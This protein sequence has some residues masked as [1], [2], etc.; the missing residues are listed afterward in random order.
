MKRFFAVLLTL[1]LLLPLP[2]LA[3]DQADLMKKIDELS[4]ELDKLKQ[5]MQEMQK[6]EEVREEKVSQVEKKTDAEIAKALSVK[7]WPSWL[8]LGGDYRFRHDT[9]RGDVHDY[10]QYNPS[11]RNQF[12]GPQGPKFLISPTE[13]YTA[14]NESL[15]TNRFR[16]DISAKA[17]E[18]I[19]FKGRLLA[20]KSWGHQTAG[21]TEG[22]FFADRAFGPFDG[23]VGHV[24]E[25]SV[26]RVDRAYVTWS[27][28][29]NLPMWISVGRR[30][31]TDGAPA[32]L[33]LNEERSGTAGV[34]C[35]LVNYAF[36]G[37][38]I[39]FAPDIDFLPGSYAKI[40]Y[41]RGY[42]SGY[43]LKPLNDTDD[44]N[45]L[46]VNV[47]PYDT[48][49]LHIELQWNR[50][51][52]IFNVPPD[53]F[54]QQVD[55]GLLNG[56]SPSGS[57]ITVNTPV[58]TNLGDIDQ[59]GILV[60]GKIPDLGPGDLNWFG[61]AALSVT[62]PNSNL[63]RLPIAVLPNDQFM[64]AGF[65]LGYDEGDKDSHTGHLFYVG[66][67]YDIK[68]WRTKIG[69]EYNYGS[70]NWITFAPA[71]D[72][73]W[74]SKLGTKGQVFEIYA[75]QE[76]FKVPISKRGLAFLRLGY[77]YYDFKYTNS[78]NW[79]G[80]PK[81]IDDLTDKDPTSQQDIAN[82]QLL[83]PLKNAWDLYFTFDVRF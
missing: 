36:D 25:D 58:S 3:V 49:N 55:T 2:A 81:K 10:L 48:D 7:G 43:E 72:D 37:A 39:G 21:P 22:E 77:Q 23:T 30:P 76:L 24:P 63:F 12:F 1:A 83:A 53:G 35:F 46:G 9:L 51:F 82:T 19:T 45:F 74:T 47:V 64:T 52:D 38:T 75:I 29:A 60:M 31:S 57:Y 6:K 17:L 65:G 27:N 68:P 13:G 14:R 44:V 41:G 54:P 28:V 33:K 20:Y 32:N 34:P 18:D 50:A 80:Y 78:N 5:Q 8:E 71:A 40:C 16:L 56:G 69:L 42:D 79:V 4:R 26:V 67:R 59:Y 62:H 73:I 11:A 66:G 15:M 61:A 70:R